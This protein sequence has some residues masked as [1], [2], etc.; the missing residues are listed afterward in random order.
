MCMLKRLSWQFLLCVAARDPYPCEEFATIQQRRLAQAWQIRP[1][2]VQWWFLSSGS[3]HYRRTYMCA[4]TCLMSDLRKDYLWN[5][6]S[7]VLQK[8]HTWAMPNTAG[9]CWL[10]A[11]QR[12]LGSLMR[13]MDT[14]S[15]LYTIYCPFN[16]IFALPY[17]HSDPVN[18][19]ATQSQGCFTPG[20]RVSDFQ[21]NSTKCLWA[22][23]LVSAKED[24]VAI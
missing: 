11:C 22:P 21:A 15:I 3:M 24:E 18:S 7:S 2:I 8:M 19:A 4:P 9:E 12:Q 20:G 1:R 14:F 16:D 10:T 23:H 5:A 17:K 6:R 13:V